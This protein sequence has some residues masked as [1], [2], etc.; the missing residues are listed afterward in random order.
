MQPFY[1][2][3]AMLKREKILVKKVVIAI[4]APTSPYH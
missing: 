2:I 1:A 4:A 3:K